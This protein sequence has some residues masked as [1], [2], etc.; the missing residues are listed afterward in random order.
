MQKP[1]LSYQQQ[2]RYSRHIMLVQLDI[3]GQEKLWQSHALIVGLGGL[4]CPVA[5]YLAASGVGTLTLVDNDVV[6]ATNLQ[7]QVLYKQTDVGSLKTHAAK[8]Q[9]TSLNDEIDI[10]TIDAFLDKDF[11]LNTLLNT[12]DVVIDCSDNLATR[13]LLNSA[14]YNT[15]TPLVSGSAIRME[16]QVACFTMAQNSHCYGC[17]SQLFSE[18]TQSCSES[19]VLSP[20]VGLIGSIQ[21]TEALKLLAGLPSKLTEQLLLV[22]GLSMEFNRFNITKNKHCAVCGA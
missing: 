4:G 7:R 3:D 14:C 2:L 21:A 6:D 5:Q 16:G 12:V 10:H 20:I 13:N 19:G 8:A 15:N 11:A 1:P 22:D 17:L 18:Q 9:L